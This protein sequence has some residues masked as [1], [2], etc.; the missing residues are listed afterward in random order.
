MT[1]AILNILFAIIHSPGAIVQ[2]HH[3]RPDAL[4]QAQ[5]GLGLLLSALWIVS[6]V[7]IIRHHEHTRSL[8]LATAAA[9]ILR[10]ETQARDMARDMAD[11]RQLLHQCV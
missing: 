8:T 9:T 3:G 6:A 11:V 4:L 7:M 2:L 1:I 10:R 5:A